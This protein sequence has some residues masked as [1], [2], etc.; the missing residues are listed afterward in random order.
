MTLGGAAQGK[1]RSEFAL[2]LE[3]LRT[4][5]QSRNP[6]LREAEM[7]LRQNRLADAR[8]ALS[9]F[10]EKQPDDI[11][12]LHLLGEA[13]LQSGR[14]EEA[15]ALLAK[16][17]ALAPD[18][19]AARY[20]Y[21]TALVQLNRLEAAAE[22][23][24]LLLQR[25]PGNILYRQL[26][27]TVLSALG[28]HDGALLLYEGLAKDFPRSPEVLN[29][30]ASALRSVGR[31]QHCI[32]TYRQAIAL[33]PLSGE[34]YW[35][36]AGVKSYRFSGAQI[37]EMQRQ[38]ARPDLSGEDRAYFH[39]ALGKAFGDSG[40]YGKSFENY[41]RANAL[42]RL[43]ISYDPASLT[44]HVQACKRVFTEELFHVRA[45][46]GCGAAG[47]I[48]IVGMQRAG[49]TLI[50]QILASHSAIEATAELP[51]IS[52]L[53][54]H[55]GEAIAPVHASSY[56]DI[57]TQLDNVTLTSL[58]ERYLRETH[59]QR[60]LSK[61]FFVDKMPYNFLHLG[62]IHSILPNAKIIDARRH[63]LGCCFSNFSMH[64]KA[65]PLFAYRLGEL[66]HAYANY[67]ELMAHFDRVLP[68]RVHR[69]FYEDLVRSPEEEIGRLLDYLG[70]P[71]EEECLEFHRSDRAMDSASAEQVRRPI[72][73]DALS[74][75]RAYESWLSP[76]KSALGAV[77][78]VYP[79]VPQFP[80]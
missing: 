60:K 42:K 19:A 72:Y 74:Q 40:Q 31:T 39:F 37:A 28:E 59:A 32:Q 33:S 14:K 21:A 20:G 80:E 67:V 12:A 4:E 23:I 26:K 6:R 8:D 76:L 69:V 57:V 48:F 18:F 10:L 66:G 22:Q 9:L 78:D 35:S 5:R 24:E 45:G 64:F 73:H 30:Y 61:P 43:A 68:G 3:A 11:H 41:A 79:Q 58:G 46:T 55:V 2:A 13:A 27:A 54:E 25:E 7:A 49:S 15:E 77:L 29:L 71:F 36:L 44:R 65:G 17:V 34:A 50:E 75:W 62:L 70:L 1:P 53:A 16:C 47:P 38:L 56:P 63:P 52:L 51:T